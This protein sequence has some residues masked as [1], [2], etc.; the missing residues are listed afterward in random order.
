MLEDDHVAKEVCP[1]H[2][3]GQAPAQGNLRQGWHDSGLV[4]STA[5]LLWP[6]AFSALLDRLLYRTSLDPMHKAT[7]QVGTAARAEPCAQRQMSGAIDDLYLK[8]CKGPRSCTVWAAKEAQRGHR[9][10]HM[11][12]IRGTGEVAELRGCTAEG[13]SAHAPGPLQHLWKVRG[14]SAI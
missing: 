9:P 4:Q 5:C 1:F 14:H 8:P 11:R 7:A 13:V 10:Q 12:C 3:L 2:I 6:Q